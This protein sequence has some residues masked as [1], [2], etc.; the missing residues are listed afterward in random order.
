MS[1]FTK[2]RTQ[3]ILQCTND[4]SR[5]SISRIS[6]LFNLAILTAT[7]RWIA[8]AALRSN[9][10]AHISPC[11]AW[12][13]DLVLWNK[14]KESPQLGVIK[15][16]ISSVYPGWRRTQI[17]A[18]GRTPKLSTWSSYNIKWLPNSCQSYN[19]IRYSI[20]NILDKNTNC[21][22]ASNTVITLQVG[23]EL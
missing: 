19:I 23:S 1:E 10:C 6:S 18:E 8:R 20:F 11:N 14:V 22:T 16:T 13:H 15:C 2:I 9:G 12:W 5:I 3:G 4:I 17:L 21:T 7:V